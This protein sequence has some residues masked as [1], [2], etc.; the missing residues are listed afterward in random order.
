MPLLINLRHLE[1]H[2]ILLN[3]D[4][5]VDEL[6]LDSRDEVIQ[7]NQPLRYALEVQQV[8]GG[9]LLQGRL[10]LPLDCE[11]VRCLKQF[12]YPLDLKNWACH[13]PLEGEEK[14]PIVSDCVDLTPFVREDILLE[15]PRHPLCEPQ[16]RGLPKT[17]A[18][19]TKKAGAGAPVGSSAWAEL[20][21]LKF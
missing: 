11:C 15:F 3:G 8:D 16:C 5:P 10:Q 14:A 13:V 17:F 6:D 4:L 1:A 7:V 2:N 9:L 18:G 19:N 20:N 21:K 12:R